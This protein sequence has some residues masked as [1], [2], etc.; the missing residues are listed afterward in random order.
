MGLGGD[1]NFVESVEAQL[2]R[3]AGRGWGWGMVGLIVS[4]GW[5]EIGI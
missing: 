4:R 1:G 5:L 2:V 3:G